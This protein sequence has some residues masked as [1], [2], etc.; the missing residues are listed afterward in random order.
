MR[1]SETLINKILSRTFY[2][3]NRRPAPTLQGARLSHAAG[4]DMRKPAMAAPFSFD[5]ARKRLATAWRNRA[6]SLKA[7][8]F[9]IIGLVNTAVDYAIFFVARAGFAHSAAALAFFDWLS[10]RCHCGAPGTILLIAANIASWAVAVS[11]SYLLNATI[12]F[13]A[14]S[15]R[16]LSRRHYLAFVGSGIAGLI[17]NTATLIVAAQILALPVWLAKACAVLASFIVN[18]LLSHFVVFRVR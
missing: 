14:E 4:H 9:A 10:G 13:A 2:S 7:A 11:G 12:T 16:R 5:S 8:S 18:F 3:K 6:L 15:G 1:L 17:A